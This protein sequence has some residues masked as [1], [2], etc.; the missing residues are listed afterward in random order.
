MISPAIRRTKA[1]TGVKFPN[2]FDLKNLGNASC[3]MALKQYSFCA[4]YISGICA[5]KLSSLGVL[6]S[7]VLLKGKLL[8]RRA[9]GR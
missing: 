3:S 6:G 4:W 1:E 2:A 9:G 7:C 5:I 8:M